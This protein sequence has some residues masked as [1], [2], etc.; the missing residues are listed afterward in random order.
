MKNSISNLKATLT[1]NE[2]ISTEK[3]ALVKGGNCT[4]PKRHITLA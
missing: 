4:D 1:A 2:K 3:L